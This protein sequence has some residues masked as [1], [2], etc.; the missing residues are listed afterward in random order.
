MEK[1]EEVKE[2]SPEGIFDEELEEEDNE[3]IF[4]D[5]LD[6]AVEEDLISGIT[7]STASV[8]SNWKKQGL[9]DSVS[10][11]VLRRDWRSE[12]D[13]K[14]GDYEEKSQTVFYEEKGDA[15]L[16]NEENGKGKSGDNYIEGNRGRYDDFKAS[17]IDENSILKA[18]GFARKKRG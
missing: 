7:L 13:F 14:G 3:G 5:D 8:T 15:R 16:Y 12:Q 17:G 1:E 18:D 10:E 6:E 4:D 11:A 2:D 9:E